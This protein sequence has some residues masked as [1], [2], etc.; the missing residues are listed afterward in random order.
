MNKAEL[1]RNEQELYSV[2]GSSIVAKN[3]RRICIKLYTESI[4]ERQTLEVTISDVIDYYETQARNISSGCRSFA[5][6]V[7]DWRPIDDIA[8]ACLEAF[9]IINIEGLRREA[10]KRGIEPR[11]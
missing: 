10:R 3:S 6:V 5:G 1:L 11:F 8:H 9:K 4:D 7:G 2:F